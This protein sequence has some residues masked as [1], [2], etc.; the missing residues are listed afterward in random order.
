LEEVR[1]TVAGQLWG[2]LM[3]STVSTGDDEESSR[4]ISLLQ[5]LKVLFACTFR[6]LSKARCQQLSSPRLLVCMQ[7]L[8]DFFLLARGEFYETFLDEANTVM[9][10]PFSDRTAKGIMRNGTAE[11]STEKKSGRKEPD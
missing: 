6:S 2:L 3:N 7:E 10:M 9:T 1:T 11:R 4:T 8:K 5:V